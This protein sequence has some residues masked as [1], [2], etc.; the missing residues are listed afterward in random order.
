M[1][2]QGSNVQNVTCAMLFWTTQV[3]TEQNCA[4]VYEDQLALHA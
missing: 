4:L 3:P 2:V 1:V